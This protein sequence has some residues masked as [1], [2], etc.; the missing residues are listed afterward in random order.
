MEI[1]EE[2]VFNF[3]SSED[4]LGALSEI[5]KYAYDH[6]WD[7]IDIHSRLDGDNHIFEIRII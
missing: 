2:F 5:A 1:N 4:C 3:E 7:L 6:G